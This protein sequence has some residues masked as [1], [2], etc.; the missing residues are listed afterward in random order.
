M[1]INSTEFK[2]FVQLSWISGYECNNYPHEHFQNKVFDWL[3]FKQ[4][5]DYIR[6]QT[7]FC[8]LWNY[9]EN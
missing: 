5:A 1:W 7:V 6:P 9:N 3:G 8:S 4:S 2:R